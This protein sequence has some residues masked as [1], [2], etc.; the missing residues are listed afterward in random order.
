MANQWDKSGTTINSY[1]KRNELL[2]LPHTIYK[3]QLEIDPRSK[4]K[5]FK[6]KTIK[7]IE[8]N[9]RGNLCEPELGK[10]FLNRT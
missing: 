6:L 8:E 10:D 3:N 2:P 1:A 4:G 9:I 7:L 5:I